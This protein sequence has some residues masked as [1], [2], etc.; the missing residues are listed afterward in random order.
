MK[1][2]GQ[3][4]TLLSSAFIIAALLSSPVYA[5]NFFCN[6]TTGSEDL[7]TRE[8]DL[9]AF[10][11]IRVSD[12]FEV[13]IS[14]GKER[15]VK[16]R[17]DDNLFD[18]IGL[19]IWDKRLAVKFDQRIC[20]SQRP[21]LDIVMP[22]LIA[23]DVSGAV[24]TRI[25]HFSGD[26]FEFE[27][28]GAGSLRI[29]GKVDS[30]KLQVSGAGDIKARNLVAKNADVDLS[31]AGSADIHVTEKL[32]AEVSGVGS[33]KYWGDPKHTSKEVSGIGSIH[34]R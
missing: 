30:L 34:A 1:H 29:D 17:I 26:S 6:G 32:V 8:I 23:M 18:S 11:E 28:S 12:V 5:K 10:N 16:L 24:D 21:K 3:L 27:L 25:N 7:E 22:S 20:P 15:S 4:N 33:V 2:I 14:F 31:G 13:K 19:R 9:E